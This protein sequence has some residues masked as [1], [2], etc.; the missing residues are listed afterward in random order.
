AASG[1]PHGGL[2]QTLLSILTMFMDLGMIVVTPG[3]R[4]PTLQ[5]KATPYGATAISGVSGGELP[6]GEDEVAAEDLGRRVAL[7]T[8]WM[9]M[10]R[11]GRRPDNVVG[12]QTP[13]AIVS[14]RGAL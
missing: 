10:G 4:W 5:A 1:T 12:G 6:R 14:E 8:T 2:E 7:L 13:G 9:R 3:Q 11:Q